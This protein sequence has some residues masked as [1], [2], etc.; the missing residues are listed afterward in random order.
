LNTQDI[1]I[2]I[3]DVYKDYRLGVYDSHTF[4]EELQRRRAK[5]KGQE[6]PNL[7]ISQ[8]TRIIGTT[9]HAINGISLT[10]RQG[11]AVGIIGA[12]GAGKSTLLKLISHI[13]IPT[14]GAIGINGRISSMLEV[15]VGFMPDMT[16]DENIYLSG[17]ILGMSKAEV[18]R[19]M[20]QIVAFSEC[21]EFI[22][23]PLKRYS[24]GMRLKLAFSIAA[25]LDN[26]IMI[27]DEVLA[28][29]DQQ[30]QRKCVDKMREASMVQNKT[31]LYVSHNMSTIRQLCRRCVVLDR[32]RV[33]FDG[34]VE[35]G[36][37]IYSQKY[38]TMACKVNLASMGRSSHSTRKI[39]LL[40][41]RVEDREFPHFKRGERIEL[42]IDW[43][44][45]V[46][47]PSGF[48]LVN[49][50]MQDGEVLGVAFSSET[51]SAK[52][53]ESC[54]TRIAFD[55]S[56]LANGEYSLSIGFSS[57]YARHTCFD[58][59]ERCFCFEVVTGGVG[60]PFSN[61][62]HRI[63]GMLVLPDLCLIASQQS[64]QPLAT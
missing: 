11:E 31:V 3:D 49:L 27:M 30:F 12:N 23:T 24:S 51:V 36:I 50:H 57:A 43:E 26:E 60:D 1:A 39:R 32:G 42:T 55:T 64:T 44:A 16:G 2:Q 6:D 20:D 5:R 8:N 46:D 59:V 54:T 29:G 4:M 25:H 18:K 56:M 33:V 17:A 52:E 35:K 10:I 22:K 48:A 62:N 37:A 7:K 47:I 53:G 9:L 45:V 19:K 41:L 40:E 13:T 21:A 15:G 61:W 63:D 28:V 38:S 14:K 34:D 58:Y